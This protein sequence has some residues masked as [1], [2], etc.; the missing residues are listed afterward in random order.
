M[1]SDQPPSAPD[2]PQPA[3][4]SHPFFGSEVQEWDLHLEDFFNFGSPV[5]PEALLGDKAQ[6]QT[7]PIQVSNDNTPGLG[8]SVPPAPVG[9]ATSPTNDP[10][11]DLASCGTGSDLSSAPV[12]FSQ[13]T[14]S[15]QFLN[16]PVPSRQTTDNSSGN[17]SSSLALPPMRAL[18]AEP[19]FACVWPPSSE[20]SYLAQNIISQ[21]PQLDW[22]NIGDSVSTGSFNFN[23]P[24]AYGYLPPWPIYHDGF[25][26]RLSY[27]AFDP[28]QSPHQPRP[29]YLMWPNHSSSMPPPQFQCPH[30]VL[31]PSP[32][33]IL[34]RQARQ[35]INPRVRKTQ[36]Q[37]SQQA[38]RSL[39]PRSPG[40]VCPPSPLLFLPQQPFQSSRL[41]G[42]AS[43]APLSPKRAKQED[44]E[45]DDLIVIGDR[46]LGP[47][48]HSIL[49]TRNLTPPMK[50][51]DHS[52][53]PS[54]G[55]PWRRED[56]RS[57]RVENNR[58][59][60]KDQ[61]TQFEKIPSRRKDKKKVDVSS[62]YQ[63]L[64]A[65][66]TLPDITDDET[67]EPIFTYNEFG[68]WE[69]HLRFDKNQL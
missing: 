53:D 51:L 39:D 14:P 29:Q 60:M 38:F 8:S 64:A 33:F 30:S 58:W 50:Q 25:D 17:T 37:S 3:S 36:S 5:L 13:R 52:G 41:V 19:E 40:V 20:A 35:T 26:P 12:I 66:P 16:Q 61:K 44:N 69:Y 68:E 45:D 63:S 42:M 11:Q 56:C 54:L 48:V 18:G 27:D 43:P 57:Q 2:L 4:D 21:N 32:S 55:P 15:I 24:P 65:T 10:R 6:S 67:G 7:N 1:S 9:E 22:G 62:Y 49:T 47:R 23:H 46:N 31:P 59:C 34:P 28:G